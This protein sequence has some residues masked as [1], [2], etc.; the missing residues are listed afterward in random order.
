MHSQTLRQLLRLCEAT[1]S[2]VW[3][4]GQQGCCCHVFSAAVGMQLYAWGSTACECG[5]RAQVG[6][7]TWRRLMREDTG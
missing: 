2:Q 7:L 4:T 1:M 6:E 3:F 5:K